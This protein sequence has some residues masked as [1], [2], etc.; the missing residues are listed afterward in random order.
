M[1]EEYKAQK[2]VTVS[3]DNCQERD[4]R[5]EAAVT[6]LRDIATELRIGIL[7]TRQSPQ[8]FT[9]TVSPLVPFG[10]TREADESGD[11]ECDVSP[12]LK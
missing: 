12:G 6:S 4:D 1:Q 11:K 5:L 2:S 7:V 3:V 10:M 9:V 8:A